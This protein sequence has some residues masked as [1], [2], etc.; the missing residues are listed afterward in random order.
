MEHIKLPK[1]GFG[2]WQLSPEQ[3]HKSVIEAIEIGYRHIDTA[4]IYKNEEGVGEALQNVSVK[5]EDLIIATKVWV[6]KLS[7]KRL[8]KSTIE[9][10]EKLQMDY[11]DILYVHW[12]AGLYKAKKTMR[13]LN[14]LVNEEKTRYIAVSNFTPKLIKKA[15]QVSKAPIIANQIETHPMLQQKPMKKFLDEK[16]MYLV[17]YSP[18]GRGKALKLEEIQN[19]AKSHGV[20]PAQVCLAW[21]MEKGMIPIPKATSKD[22]IHDNFKAL[23]LTLTE[24]E[25]IKID[26]ISTEKRIINPGFLSPKWGEN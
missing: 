12:P 24:E 25:I 3:A 1:I 20:S 6:T 9:S 16:G 5:R 19:I 7:P 18:L 2:T 14:Q 21:S 26:N 13:A 23:E 4:Q 10:L 17:A 8:V 15:I 22:H 11:V